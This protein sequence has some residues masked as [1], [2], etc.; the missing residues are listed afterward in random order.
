[1]GCSGEVVVSQDGGIEEYSE[2]GLAVRITYRV[3]E[4]LQEL[5]Q[6]V[7]SGGERAV[8]TAVYML[9]MQDLVAAP[10]RCVDEINQG[11]DAQ[12][13]RRI[14]EILVKATGKLD[15]CQYFLI[16]P[17]VGNYCVVFCE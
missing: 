2:Y 14:F 8:A 4:P 3:G 11:M 16:T 9:S 13:E 12:N 15:T 10:F 17:K 6:Y 1:M 5:N 7:Q